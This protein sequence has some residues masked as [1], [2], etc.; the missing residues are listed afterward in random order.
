MEDNS[1]NN[2]KNRGLTILLVV[3]IFILLGALAVMYSKYT[4]QQNSLGS[5]G[6]MQKEIESQKNDLTKQ[7]TNMLTQY[8]SMKTNNDTINTKLEAE[9]SKVKK[10]LSLNASNVEKIRLYKKELETLRT[11]MRSYI[12]QID[13]LN[14]KNQKLAYE[15]VDVRGKLDKA[16]N[17]NLQLTDQKEKLT[18]KVKVASVITAKDIMVTSLN[19]RSKEKAKASRVAKIKVC[20]TLRENNVAE[21]GSKIVYVR[22][23]RPDNQLLVSPDNGTFNFQGQPINYTARREVNYEN[24]DVDLCIFWDNNGQ[25]PAGNYTVDIF[26]EGNLIGSTTF[27]LEK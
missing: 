20:F 27:A 22:I 24:K 7:L 23:S 1:M 13:S 6:D 26:S 15:N 11:I 18:S 25:L 19:K 10:L 12:V 3:L 2:S 14:Q 17:E 16:R 8:D 9:K 5:M 4:D 21:A